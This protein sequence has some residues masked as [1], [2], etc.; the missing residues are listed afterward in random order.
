MFAGRI[1][2]AAVL[3]LLQSSLA[4]AKVT[5]PALV[6]DGMVLQQKAP[7]RVWGW[8]ADGEKVTVTFRGQSHTVTAKAD[9]SKVDAAKPG[10]A[11]EGQWSV[12]LNPLD[13][14]GP[15][16][17]TVAGENRIVLKDVFVGDVWVC[18]GQSNMEWPLARAFE[19][20][21]DIDAAPDPALRTFNVGR[22][23]AS[24]PQRDVTGKWEGAAPDTRG[25]FSAVGFYFGRALRQARKVPIGLI[26]TSWGGTPAEAWTSRP[27][28]Q[29]WGLP[30]S[31]FAAL[32]PPSP[33]EK[34]A[35]EQRVAV[36]TAAGRPQGTFEDQG[37]SQTA[38]S[39]AL[40]QTQT[41]DWKA[42]PL[43]QAWERLGGDMQLDGAVWFRRDVNVPPSW[44]GRALEL[45]L[46]AI[47]DWDTTHFNGVKV[48]STG[49]E[50]PNFWAAPRRYQVPASA[51]KAG[52][53]VLAVRV[54][55]HGGDGGF[56]GPA[57]NMWL[58]PAGAAAN[59][60]ISL[61]GEWR[62]K[63]ERTRP[64]A[65]TPPGLNQNLPSVLYNGMLAPLLPYAIKGATWY[66]GESNTGRS[67]Q[68]RSLL[69]AMIRSW[70][71]DW[72]QKDFPFLIVQLAPYQAIQ[73]E[74]MES[75]WAALREA[76]WQVTTDLPNVG[77]AVITDVG[78]ERDIH[79][80]KKEP[81]GERLALAAR[82]VAYG[83]PIVASGPS[84]R[85]A[86]V[87]KGKVVVS[88]D[89]VGKG[90]EQR[91]ERLTGFAIAGADG[92]FVHADATLAGTTVV[93]S[94]PK[95]AE[96]AFVRFG[97]ADYPV[98]NLWNKDG[99]PA[100]PFRTDQR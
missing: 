23:L 61:T 50:T 87:E 62:F 56:M 12:T 43:P 74:P 91:G 35:Y 79:P 55:D 9:L 36:W 32:A 20:K 29:A 14:G 76:Q 39:W 16:E 68:Y 49:S 22:Q 21:A 17:L 33:A 42:L 8:A 73:A 72:Q 34:E 69:G 84:F 89:N 99:L 63:A 31:A 96:P 24:S 86:K 15:F 70:R 4:S 85:S 66:Q 93:V 92:K 3:V 71:A 38:R 47:D 80:T 81:V 10:G 67:A 7:V 88:F 46:G 59:E 2:L 64:S 52:R 90:L 6:S 19:P 94:S 48:G 65:P 18:S 30:E 37:P 100:V 53:A 28:L 40:P 54:W 45:H 78:D 77:L 75:G 58:A 44:A 95:I 26:H 27:A 41:G 97:W 82:K 1:T 60:R 13:P 83:E 5:L 57:G 51:V 11:K 25:R 98:V